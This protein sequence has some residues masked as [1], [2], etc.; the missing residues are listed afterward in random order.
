MIRK[1]AKQS[2]EFWDRW[3]STSV[4]LLSFRDGLLKAVDADSLNPDPVSLFW[5]EGKVSVIAR[6]VTD[7]LP[8]LPTC[9]PIQVDAHGEVAPAIGAGAPEQI[10]AAS[11][12]V[13]SSTFR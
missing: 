11:D 12:L 1:S 4:G 5:G 10:V 8:L 2:G 3:A 7:V 6:A 9:D 13:P